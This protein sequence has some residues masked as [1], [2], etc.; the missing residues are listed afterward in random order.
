MTK[1]FFFS[2]RRRHTRCALVTGVQTCALPI[3]QQAAVA[4]IEWKMVTSWPKNF[5]G[6]GVGA[7]RFAT[8]VDAMSGGRLKV[9]IYA[10]GELVPALEVFDAVSRGTAELGHSAAYSW[11]GNVPAAQFRSE[12]RRVGKECV[13]TCRF[14]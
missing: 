9:K 8:L 12:E 7:E 11:K 2:S 4:T 6:V 13:G 14:G 5:P 1:L 10:A 3:S